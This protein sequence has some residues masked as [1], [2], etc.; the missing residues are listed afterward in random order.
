MV[1]SVVGNKNV[2]P[3]VEKNKDKSSTLHGIGFPR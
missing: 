2:E 1:Q 3:G